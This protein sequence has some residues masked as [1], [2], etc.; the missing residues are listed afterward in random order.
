MTAISTSIVTS[1]DLSLAA[2]L[3][4][5]GY[6][7]FRPGQERAIET[8]LARGR[9]LYVAP[10]G[11]GKSLVYQL[12][13]LILPGTTIVVSPLVALMQ[14][15]VNALQ[16]RGVPA[17]FLAATL[18]MEEIDRRL[19][20]AASGE[21]RLLYVAPERLTTGG[22]QRLA[23]N[24]QCPLVAIDEAHCI[25][26]WGHD[27]RPEYMQIGSV[28]GHF[29]KA[30]VLACTATATP[31]VRD[32]IVA[33]LALGADTPQ[34]VHGFARPNLVL[35][36]A[37]VISSRDRDA[38]VDALL[39]EALG[40]PGL[41]PGAAIVYS[42]TRAACYEE[43]Q[44]LER[45]GWRA[46]HYH[47][48]L[49][50]SLR[51][52]NQ[53]RFTQGELQV[54]VATNAFGM[55]IDRSDVRAVVHLAPPASLESYYQEVGRAGRDG[56]RA[57]GLLLTSASDMALRR[58]L[59]ESNG[60]GEA[61]PSAVVE[62]KWGLFLELMRWAEG[63]SC[64]HD[65]I[66]RYFGDH[67]EALGG[68]GQCDVCCALPDASGPPDDELQLLVRKALSGVARVHGRFGLSAAVKLLRGAKDERL[69]RTGL[70]RVRTFGILRNETEDWLT[71]LLRRLVTAGWVV[72]SGD[73]RPIVL[74]TEGGR[75]VM[76]GRVP[77]RLVLPERVG[78][79]SR[80]I[81]RSRGMRAQAERADAPRSNFSRGASDAEAALDDVSLA[82]FE[83]LRAH[84]LTVAR[85]EAVPPFVVASDRTLRDMARARPS[86]ERE[87]LS[88]YGMGPVKAARYGAGFLSILQG[89][90]A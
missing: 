83:A 41:Q 48:G 78:R 44:R 25:S 67:E 61:T 52:R 15:Q 31:V 11:G 10:T 28:L 42:P 12:P 89:R 45:A 69:E 47:A 3:C 79:A 21:F 88:V 74:L 56:E 24:L 80:G 33:R 7:E 30:R 34:I 71:R 68:C 62:H 90:D 19:R 39:H 51:E 20:A 14:D 46:G 38:C 66:L 77:A 32:E 85:A 60:D 1:S 53:Q 4:A 63:G 8:L 54:M 37:E 2:G 17:T 35:R 57:Y 6:S 9:L 81:A 87:L 23:R 18:G 59:I 76:E 50:P 70:D 72:F 13:A 5:L 75:A 86:S 36:A 22:F 65:A 16:A 64:R 27:F 29:P 26:E 49:E 40:A 82:L 55:G 43:S 58:R 73:D 84:R